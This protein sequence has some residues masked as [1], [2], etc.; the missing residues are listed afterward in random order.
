MEKKKKLLVYNR[1][2]FLVS[3]TFIYR[4]TEFLRKTYDIHLLAKEFMNPHGFDMDGFT[5]HK[6]QTPDSLTDRV[7][8]RLLRSRNKMSLALDLSSHLRV[9]SLVKKGKIS[10]IFAHFGPY[11][12]EILGLARG[13]NIPL[14]AAF[15]GH[16]ASGMLSD[17]KYREK[18][19][20]LFDYAA[21]ITISSSHMFDLLRLGQW[22]EKVRVIPYGVNPEKFRNGRSVDTQNNDR[23]NILHAGRVVPTKGVPDLIRVFLE[24]AEKY[25][26]IDLTVAGDGS[27]LED[28]KRLAESSKYHGRIEFLGA[29]PQ[30]QV[31]VLFEKSDI[32]VLNS[33]TDSKGDMEGTPNT[34]LESMCM[35]KAV[36][37]A[38]HAGIPYVI[39]HGKNGLLADEYDNQQLKNNI[40]KL[41]ANKN[42]RQQL[43]QKA[44]ETI[45]QSYTDRVM[46]EKIGEL[47]AEVTN[48]GTK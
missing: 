24:L 35:G 34:I 33:R 30:Q 46:Q 27:E 32:F 15:H 6:L 22:E 1:S 25:D 11:A 14:I 20:E 17:K 7:F 43:G 16:D 4:Q 23:I 29:V 39:D 18:L 36:V 9:R 19:P 40:N 21:Y 13:Y 42:L 10:A 5:C 47:V 26:N 44:N 38:R 31:K 28:A 3:E 12:L 41:I 48:S 8:N 45:L 37:S 2:F